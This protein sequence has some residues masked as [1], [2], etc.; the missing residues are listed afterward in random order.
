MES[1]CQVK[2]YHTELATTCP[3]MALT[4]AH[5]SETHWASTL[6][7]ANQIHD[8]IMIFM[9]YLTRVAALKGLDKCLG[10]DSILACLLL[11]NL[12]PHILAP[13]P[14]IRRYSGTPLNGHPSTADT[15]DITDNSESPDCP[16]IHFN[17]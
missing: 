4:E 14:S 17:T 13:L 1:E 16:S 5:D 2:A 15:H 8:S 10:L 3:C 12:W 11:L 6:D 7:L 9:I